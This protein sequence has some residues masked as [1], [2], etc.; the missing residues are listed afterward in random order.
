MKKGDIIEV[1]IRNVLFPNK[2]IGQFENYT[3]VVK[4]AFEGQ[5]VSCKISK[6]KKQEL[7]CKLVEVLEKGRL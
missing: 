7:E 2:A 3:V 1:R 5:L 4:G 6:I